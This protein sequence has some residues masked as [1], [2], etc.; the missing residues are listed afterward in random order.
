MQRMQVGSL[1]RELRSHKLQG[2][3]KSFLE[4]RKK[5]KTKIQIANLQESYVLCA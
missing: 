3:A 1:V 5:K 2:M 4:E